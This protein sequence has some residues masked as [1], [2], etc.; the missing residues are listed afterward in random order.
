MFQEELDPPNVNVVQ[1]AYSGYRDSL[2]DGDRCGGHIR[3]LAFERVSWFPPL[4]PA[5]NSDIN[6][7]FEV[8][9]L[10]SFDDNK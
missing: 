5:G 2:G 9:F 3:D 7:L 4:Y 8:E 1:T 10:M 6:Y